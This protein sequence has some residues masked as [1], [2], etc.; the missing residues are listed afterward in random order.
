MISSYLWRSVLG[1]YGPVSTSFKFLFQILLFTFETI[2]SWT[3]YV[4]ATPSLRDTF[5]CFWFCPFSHS[6][7]SSWLSPLLYCQALLLNLW[8]ISSLIKTSLDCASTSFCPLPS[9]EALLPSLISPVPHCFQGT[10][11][12]KGSDYFS[13][14]ILLFTPPSFLEF[15]IPLASLTSLTPWLFSLFFCRIFP[16]LPWN[17]GFVKVSP[18]VF[19]D[20]PSH[21][22]YR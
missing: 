4:D 5:L 11:K 8:T 16:Y 1:S 20:G 6:I 7:P 15:F 9:F 13:V 14:F 2:T 18:W 19:H 10:A 12:A 3:Q 21:S 22:P 17:L